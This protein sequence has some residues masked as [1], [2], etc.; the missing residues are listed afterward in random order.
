ME[1]ALLKLMHAIFYIV[2]RDKYFLKKI[3]LNKN[4]IYIQ[5]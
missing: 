3:I 4:E 5:K 1:K 2:P